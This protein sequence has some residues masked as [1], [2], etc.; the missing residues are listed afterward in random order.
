MLYIKVESPTLC[1]NMPNPVNSNLDRRKV[2][3]GRQEK[4]IF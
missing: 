2:Q 1:Y 4:L 3:V